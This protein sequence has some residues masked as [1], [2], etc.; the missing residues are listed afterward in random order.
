MDFTCLL[1]SVES[2]SCQKS[3]RTAGLVSLFSSLRD[4]S[5]MF[6]LPDLK[7]LTL[8][9]LFIF[10]VGMRASPI[11]VTPSWLEVKPL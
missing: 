7:A 4:C 5:P 2:D 6:L 1:C 3:G 11:M 9:N 10:I 8:E